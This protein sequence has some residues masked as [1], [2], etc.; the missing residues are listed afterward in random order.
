MNKLEAPVLEIRNLTKTYGRLTAL[1]DFS[2][3]VFPGE[4]F[5]IL[6]PNGSGKTTTLGILLDILKADSGEFYWFGEHPTDKQ[7]QKIGSLLE[8]P[9]FYPH[10]SAVNNL[11]IVA[12]IKNAPYNKIDELL[13][14]MGLSERKNSKYKTYA[15]GMKQRLAIAAAL[16]CTSEPHTVSPQA[17]SIPALSSG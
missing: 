16:I 6:G 7:R 2:L 12:D 14:L 5:A 15:L 4:V 3:Q 11:R 1:S 9:I 8:T 13:S 10:L 17:T